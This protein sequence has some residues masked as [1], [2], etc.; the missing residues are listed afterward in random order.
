MDTLSSKHMIF[1]ISGAA[2]VSL[3]SYSSIF[4][5]TGGRDSWLAMITASVIILLIVWYFMSA[6]KRSNCY[7]IKEIHYKA[8]G[9]T[10]GSIILFLY[11]LMLLITAVECSAVEAN[12]IHTNLFIETPMWYLILF[13]IVPAVY[14]IKKGY[15]SIFLTTI[16]TVILI[17]LAFATTEVLAEKYKDYNH[18]LPLMQVGLHKNFLKSILQIL[19]VYGSLFIVLPYI[20]G[21]L[22]K[23]G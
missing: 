21:V 14:P 2:I 15:T 13:F 12:S 8:Y 9:K 3:N 6:M 18:L 5:R 20:S 19:G 23:K 22:E 1:L 7:D 17:Y 16:I 4:I 11:A 10:L